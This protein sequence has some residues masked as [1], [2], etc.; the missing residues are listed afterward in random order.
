VKRSVI[1]VLIYSICCA[2]L[3][4]R[5]KDNFKKGICDSVKVKGKVKV[6]PGLN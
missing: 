1:Y 6:V 4:R 3:G 5:A 2:S